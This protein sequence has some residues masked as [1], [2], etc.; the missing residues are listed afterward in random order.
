MSES[1]APVRLEF[2][3]SRFFY[4]S[5]Y[6]PHTPTPKQ[7]QFLSL[8]SVVEALYGGAVG[9]GKSDALLMDALQYVHVEGY[10]A[11][12]LRRTFP[13]LNLPGAIMDRAKSWLMPHSDVRWNSHD[14]QF[15]FP[16][17]A[18]LTF[19]FLETEAD[20]YRYQGS[21]FHYAGFDEG[22][23]FRES[24]WTYLLSRLRHPPEGVP[25]RI[26]MGSNPGNIGHE[27]VRAR[28]VPAIDPVTSNVVYPRDEHGRVRVFVPARLR[29]N[30]YLDAVEYEKNLAALDPVTRAQLVEGDWG[31]RPPGEM[32]DAKYVEYVDSTAL[33]AG[34]RWVRAWDFAGT[35][36]RPKTR[37]DP[38][39][40]R[41]VLMGRSKDDLIYVA[42]VASLQGAP[43]EVENLVTATAA[44]DRIWPGHR[45]IRLDLEPGSAGLTVEDH[46][47][48]V[49]IGADFDGVRPT[50]P[51]SERAR[52]FAAYWR[53][54][55]VRLV[56]GPWNTDYIAELTGFPN[57]AIH[58]DQVDASSLAFTELAGAGLAVSKAIA[59]K[60][61]VASPYNARRP[62]RAA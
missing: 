13:D 36:K 60:R 6:S 46:Y 38:D 20:K 61:G 51:K 52:G 8:Q 32:F 11:L 25:L 3:P 57:E 21:E 40:T 18:T 16:S 22:T 35:K 26:R 15:V 48:R 56:R 59:P 12:I 28:F 62:S 1:S 9:G 39:W 10:A 47:S 29:D 44:R 34:I 2:G 14:K 33:P 53:A 5:P 50:G 4:L 55:R 41:G 58:D 49:L 17:G 24:E 42:D 45:C 7:A 19:G 27:W 43:S 30:P 37:R 31:A 54:G 23:Q